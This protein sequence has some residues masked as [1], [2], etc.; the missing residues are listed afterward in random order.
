MKVEII[1]L[2]ITII[3]KGLTLKYNTK[4]EMD[5][6]VINLKHKC[7]KYRKNAIFSELFEDVSDPS[8]NYVQNWASKLF[9]C[10]P[11]ENGALSWNRFFRHIHNFDLKV[12]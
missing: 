11:A 5:K 9:M 8:E 1:V 7:D 3:S 4:K 6:R 2:I 12:K 10:I